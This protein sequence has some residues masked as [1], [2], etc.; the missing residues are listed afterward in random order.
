MST[1]NTVNLDVVLSQG[2]GGMTAPTPRP[3][4]PRCLHCGGNMLR[5]SDGTTACMLCGRG[6]AATTPATTPR[7]FADAA[8]NRAWPGLL[9]MIAAGAR[10]IGPSL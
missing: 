1:P 3:P 9:G 4:L 10:P 2:G 7:P 8:Q 5:E 6:P